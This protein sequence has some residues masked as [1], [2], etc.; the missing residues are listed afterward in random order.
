MPGVYGDGS[1]IS[2]ASCRTVT[3]YT[4][5][6]NG[7]DGIDYEGDKNDFGSCKASGN[8]GKGFDNS[9]ST[10]TGVTG[11]SFTKNRI[12]MAS[13]AGGGIITISPETEIGDGSDAD[14]A[15]EVD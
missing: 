10:G 14:T 9:T 5:D 2:G 7:I 8:A 13:N 1:R 11:G 15:P 6:K 4:I 12:D 3:D